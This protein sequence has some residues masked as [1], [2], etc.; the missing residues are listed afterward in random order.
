M[1][2]LS[3]LTRRCWAMRL[4]G[5]GHLGE[6]GYNATSWQSLRRAGA[7]HHPALTRSIRHISL[8]SSHIGRFTEWKSKNGDWKLRNQSPECGQTLQMLT[9]PWQR[10]YKRVVNVGVCRREQGVLWVTSTFV[11]VKGFSEWTLDSG[12]RLLYL[13]S[14]FVCWWTAVYVRRWVYK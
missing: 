2:L 11:P 14:L 9:S 4:G 12:A 10:N 6:L 1:S 3:V 7:M 8:G 5:G 13:K